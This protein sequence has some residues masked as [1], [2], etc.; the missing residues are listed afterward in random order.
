MK[1]IGLLKSAVSGVRYR[2]NEYPLKKAAKQVCTS[3]P[4]KIKNQ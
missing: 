2:V 1:S 3:G 4:G